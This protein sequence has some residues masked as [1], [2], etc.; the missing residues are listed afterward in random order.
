MVRV[1]NT[2]LD[3]LLKKYSI[4]SLRELSDNQLLDICLDED[5]RIY[6]QPQYKINK[7][8][9]TGR[10]N[11]GAFDRFKT[12]ELIHKTNCIDFYMDSNYWLPR[13]QEIANQMDFQGELNDHADGRQTF[14]LYKSIGVGIAQLEPGES[15]E[16][17]WTPRFIKDVVS[18]HAIFTKIKIED[19]EAN[20]N[21]LSEEEKIENKRMVLENETYS[22]LQ[23]LAKKYNKENPDKE[24]IKI[25]GVTQADLVDKLSRV[26]I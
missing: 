12:I 18:K 9:R 24:K 15:T 25:F 7:D 17:D 8:P 1:T 26:T 21:E 19:L 5:S 22:A 16:V 6:V 23:E 13:H 14:E 4:R 2:S 11:R 20:E 10:M 3:H